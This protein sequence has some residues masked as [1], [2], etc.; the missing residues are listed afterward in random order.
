MVSLFKRIFASK[1]PTTQPPATNSGERPAQQ[2]FANASKPLVTEQIPPAQQAPAKSV[3][4]T[5]R[6]YAGLLTFNRDSRT[7]E[8]WLRLEIRERNCSKTI[9][10]TRERGIHRMGNVS[11]T[12]TDRED[13]VTLQ[14][15]VQK[16]SKTNKELADLMAREPELQI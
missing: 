5:V 12:P 6:T 3:H 13:K 4:I 11:G 9:K 7:G 1:Q 15:A 8:E 2:A 10:W 14:I 16:A